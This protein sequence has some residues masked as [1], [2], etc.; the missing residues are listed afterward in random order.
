MLATTRAGFRDSLDD[1]GA[2]SVLVANAALTTPEAEVLALLAT[3]EIDSSC[4]QLVA[5]LRGEGQA[6]RVTLGALGQILGDGHPGALVVAPTSALRRTAFVDVGTDGPWV[7]HRVALH[8]SVIW[9]LLGDTSPDPELPV[10]V[11]EFDLDDASAPGDSD[12][13]VATGPDRMRRRHAGA[14]SASA[15]RFLCAAAPTD[16]SEWAALVREATITGRGLLIE[17][18]DSVTPLMRRWMARADHLVWVLS[19]RSA[20]P[21]DELPDRTWTEVF[22]QANEPTDGEWLAAFGPGV[23]R[24]HRLTFDQMHRVQRTRDAVGGDLDA[25]VRRLASGPLERLHASHLTESLLGRH[26]AEP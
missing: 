22:A 11:V 20:P 9:S 10:G 3:A 7:D 23:D 16:D 25:A 6:D 18:D 24:T 8:Q 26:R 19:S 4:R 15:R 5:A 14:A 2:F 17:I 13:V 21:I 1:D 12:L